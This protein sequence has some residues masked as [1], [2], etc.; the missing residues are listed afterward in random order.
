M[1]SLPSSNLNFRSTYRVQ[2]TIQ[3]P[4]PRFPEPF[5][6]QGAFRQVFHSQYYRLQDDY[7]FTP[8]LLNHFNAG[9]TRS[10]VQNRN[11]SR[12]LSP[13]S[14]GI[15]ANATQNL[16]LPLVGFP[17]YGDQVTSLDPRAYQPGGSTFFDNQ[18]GD[19]AVQ[20]T[21]FMTYVRGRHTLKFGVETRW[22]QLNDS[23]H[24]DL[25]GNFNFQSLQ[26]AN[27][28]FSGRQGWPIASLITGAPEF[29]FATV[30]GVDPG[31]RF[32]EPTTFVQ[33]DIKVTQRLTLNL[34]VRYD[35]PYPRTEHLDKYRGFDPSVTNPAAGNRL[36]ALVGAANQ[37][38]V[39][40]P[41][42]GLI[43]PDHSNFGPRVG[44]A[45]SINSKTVVRGG[46]GLYYAPLVY[47]DF[48]R[49]GETGYSVQGGA[50]INFGFDAFIRL[51]TYP[52]LPSID[53][54]SQ[55]VFN[56][57]PADVEGFDNSFKTGR[58]AQYSLNVQRELPANIVLSVSYI[59]SK[60]TRLRSSFKPPNAVPFEDL[61]L[62]F[63]LLNRNLNYVTG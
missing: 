28:D 14:L 6:G 3:G 46:Y 53:P 36:G 54:T 42:R 60:G 9:F 45:Y 20:L 50:N 7:T 58:S 51:S 23:N 12:G 44:F 30:Q 63:P 43:K 18:D 27:G 4:F 26:T 13:V 56:G 49:G 1:S 33:D 21:D 25:G 59:G 8:K 5:V 11:I 10:F 38:G 15:P 61:K 48:G 17:N 22:Q 41:Y 35:I 31:F 37:G 19:N 62:G 55:F 29:S 34:G 32:F 2:T 40:S 47:N 24:F 52:R 39:G 57:A 16:A